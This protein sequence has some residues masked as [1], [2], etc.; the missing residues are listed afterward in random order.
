MAKK[1]KVGVIFGGRSGEHEVSLRSARSVIEAIDR[2]KYQVVPL[3]ISKQGRWLS[4][5]ESAGLLPASASSRL[6]EK[7]GESDRA[8]TI[9]ADP[10]RKGL[11]SLES[12][13]GDQA[14][15]EK[16]DVIFPA[17]HGTYGE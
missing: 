8:L 9:L 11:V 10:S 1:L 5:S 3:A 14:A 6:P 12:G 16:V 17:L 7:V 13:G 2:Q 4:P 15:P